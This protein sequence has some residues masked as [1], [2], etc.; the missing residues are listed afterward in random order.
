M[1]PN[2]EAATQPDGQKVKDALADIK[3]KRG[4]NLKHLQRSNT[5]IPSIYGLP[6]IHKPGKK[7]RPIT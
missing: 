2:L 4:V 7:L 1:Q 6:K 5:K 3:N